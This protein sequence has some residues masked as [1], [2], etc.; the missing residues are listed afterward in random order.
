MNQNR[1][2]KNEIAI[3]GGG[4]HGRVIM[5]SLRSRGD[6]KIIGVFDDKAVSPEK[7]FGQKCLGPVS[8][9]S[10]FPEIKKVAVGIGDNGIRKSLVE[11]IA[12]FR[13][14]IEFVTV[15]HAD[16]VIGSRVTLG[17]GT[18]VMA[19]V[20]VNCDTKIGSHCVL[21]TSSSVDHDCI[22]G[23]FSFLSP[24][25]NVAGGVQIGES[26]FLGIGAKVAPNLKVND[27]AVIGAGAVVLKNVDQGQRVFG[28]SGP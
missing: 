12:K 5:D 13:P 2:T 16:A 15:V 17:P 8:A 14:D 18:V 3:I 10:E 26:C 28:I 27:Q 4:G 11:K 1:E 9:L 19:G 21:N 7:L 23:D 6:I 20:V 25:V 22:L 24:G